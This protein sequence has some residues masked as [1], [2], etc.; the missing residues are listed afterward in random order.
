MYE[1][2]NIRTK[3]ITSSLVLL[4]YVVI[5]HFEH[6]YELDYFVQRKE[7]GSKL[8]IC[9]LTMFHIELP[10]KIRIT[11]KVCLTTNEGMKHFTN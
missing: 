7:F 10:T 2:P 11:E 3:R 9:V 8:K 4:W 1:N 5:N 6:L